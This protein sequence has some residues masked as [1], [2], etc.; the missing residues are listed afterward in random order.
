MRSASVSDVS[1]DKEAFETAAPL[2][3][4]A[5]KAS[6]YQEK[7]TFMAERK[8]ASAKR[9]DKRKNRG[10]RIIW[11]NTPDSKERQDT[12]RRE[13]SVPRQQTLSEKLCAE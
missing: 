12:H 3:D 11:F 13:V 9:T 8:E 1:S 4:S 2:Y 6:G 5:L 10:R 7:I